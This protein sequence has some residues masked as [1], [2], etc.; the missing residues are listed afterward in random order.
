MCYTSG[1]GCRISQWRG[2][3][4]ASH[5]PSVALAS[6]GEMLSPNTLCRNNKKLGGKN[7]RKESK[8]K[9]TDHLFLSRVGTGTENH[10]RESK[11]KRVEPNG[12]SDQSINEQARN[13]DRARQRTVVRT[14]TT[15][16]Q[17]QPSTANKLFEAERKARD[18]V[19]GRRVQESISQI[20]FRDRGKL[21]CLY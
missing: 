14:K 8:E 2:T 10:W 5:L 6:L 17:S 15:G 16:K 19:R 1:V 20:A 12:I 9:K 21:R 7:Y 4:V 3:Q 18:I 11:N 13:R